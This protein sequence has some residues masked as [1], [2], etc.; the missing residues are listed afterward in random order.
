MCALLHEAKHIG[1]HKGVVYPWRYYSPIR[2]IK[3][4]INP[5]HHAVMQSI[6]TFRSKN[7]LNELEN[8][9]RREIK[10][11][12][13]RVIGSNDITSHKMKSV[14]RKYYYLAFS[15]GKLAGGV[16]SNSNFPELT[17]EDKRWV[18]TFLRKEFSF[19]KNF[20]QDIQSNQGK[21]PYSRRL[22]LY[23]KTLKSVYNSGRILE[24]P[25]HTL[26]YWLK[27]PAEHCSQCIYLAK[28]SPY[29]KSNIPTIPGSG[30]TSCRAN[31]KCQIQCKIVSFFEYKKIAHNAPTRETLLREMQAFK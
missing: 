13:N 29:I 9:F 5:K 10:E 8:G 2:T 17:E 6:G 16:I 3:T 24:A 4:I 23:V 18:E 31:C 20:V 1:G 27:N 7:R 19:W 26:Y 12:F 28:H 21:L 15:L 14:F 11:L 22:E 30:S 25:P